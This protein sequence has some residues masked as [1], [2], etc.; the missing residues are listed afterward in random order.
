MTA[1]IYWLDANVFIQAKNGPY[2]FTLVPQFWS[3]LSAQLELGVIRSSKMVYDEV[4]DGNDDLAGWFK[5]RKEKGL[6]HHVSQTVQQGYGPIANYVATKFKPHQAGE[7]LAGAD[8]WLIAHAMTS[9]GFVVTQE[10]DRS[11]KAKIKIPT[12]CR[13]FG[14]PWMNTYEML[15]KLE[16]NLGSVPH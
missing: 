16:A 15:T 4:I 7:F 11:H 9:D 13:V 3:F 6:C 12:I 14:V 1:S 2:A 10:S 8:G 5:Q